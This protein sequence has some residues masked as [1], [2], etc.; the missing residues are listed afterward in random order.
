MSTFTWNEVPHFW[1]P[2][3]LQTAPLAAL[4]ATVSQG[5]D[6]WMYYVDESDA[7]PIPGQAFEPNTPV[8]ALA[9]SDASADVFAV[10]PS[11]LC[12]TSHRGG[13]PGTGWDGWQPA[14]SG[15]FDQGTPI[16]AVRSRPA[17]TDL[18]AVGLNGQIWTS[19]AHPPQPFQGWEQ[20]LD[21]TFELGAPV[22]AISSR[23]GQIDLFCVDVDG[24]MMTAWF[25]ES[26]GHWQGWNPVLDGVFTPSTPVRAMSVSLGAIDLFAVGLDGRVWTAGFHPPG[27]W[28]E[29]SP[30]GDRIFTQRTPVSCVAAAEVHLLAVGTDGMPSMNSA[31]WPALEFGDWQGITGS[32]GSFAQL[33]ELAGWAEDAIE[34][35]GGETLGFYGIL[36]NGNAELAF[37]RLP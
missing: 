21:H 6:G 37:T 7:E 18:F 35:P 5:E 15:E 30:V 28:Q 10:G 33:T 36:P 12:L 11:S 27:S 20:I 1:S 25:I 34:A 8:T 22:T 14:Q 23:P 3:R 4:Q 24:Q 26:V 29:W 13:P 19:W 31:P 16:A 2:S 32:P 9:G 17:W